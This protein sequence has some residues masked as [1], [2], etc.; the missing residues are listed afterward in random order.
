MFVF[1][2][3]R[4]AVLFF[5]LFACANS[6]R[7]FCGNVGDLSP[8]VS[9]L[10]LPSL[11]ICFEAEE[12]KKEKEEQKK[13]SERQQERAEYAMV[14]SVRSLSPFPLSYSLFFNT[15]T[16]THTHTTPDCQSLCT[17]DGGCEKRRERRRREEEEKNF[18][19]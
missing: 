16:H 6:G 9:S 17:L 3:F 2:F 14:G 1:R 13:A 4:S 10:S 15:H 12:E 19:G 7:V 11:S 8:P 18:G 5:S